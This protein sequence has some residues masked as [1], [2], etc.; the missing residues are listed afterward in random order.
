MKKS[1]EKY[2]P[3]RPPK[4][5]LILCQARV[6]KSVLEAAQKL[7]KSNGMKFQEVVETAL[8]MFIDQA[9]GA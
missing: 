9:K 2:L 4:P 7:A 3:T 1:I 8:K 5:E 6:E